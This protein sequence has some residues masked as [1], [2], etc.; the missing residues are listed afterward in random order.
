LCISVLEH[1]PIFNEAVNDM[2]SLFKDDGVLIMTLPYSHNNYCENI[3]QLE[4]V[5]DNA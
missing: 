3:Y 1:I 2:V 4:E 5:D